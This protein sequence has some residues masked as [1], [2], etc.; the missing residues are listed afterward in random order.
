MGKISARK[1]DTK[2]IRIGLAIEATKTLSIRRAAAKYG[3][4]RSTVQDRLKGTKSPSESKAKY[5]TLTAEEE[6]EI[7]RWIERLDDMAIP[8]RAIHVYQMVGAILA[9][10]PADPTVPANKKPKGMIGKHWISRFL[11]RHPQL[12]SHFAGRID[13]QRVVAGQPAGIQSFFN[14][15]GEVRSRRKI[16][17]SNT[18]NA[19]EKGFTIGQA[20][21]GKV[22]CR[23]RRRNVRVRHPGNREW[24]S[25]MECISADGNVLDPLFIYAG[26]AHLMGNHDY[27]EDEDPAVF[28]ISDNGWTN[29]NIGFLWLKDHFE[30]VTRPANPAEYRL[31]ILDGHSSH[32][33]LE[34]LD[35]ARDHKIEILCF[36]PH[37]THLLQPLDVGIFGP[38]GTYYSN[39]VDNW[40]RTHPY[41]SINKG[42][43]LPMCQRARRKA[44]TKKNIL[45]AFA[46]AGIHSFRRRK[47]LDLVE[48]VT[49][50]Q[51]EFSGLH[52]QNPK[53]L[54]A[55][56]KKVMATK[57]LEELRDWALQL[58]SG[59]D[60]ALTRATIAEETNAQL[61][62]APKKSQSNRKQITKATLVASKYLHK[63]R[64]ERIAKEAAAAEKKQ[65]AATK[66]TATPSTKKTTTT[67]ANKRKAT[68]Q[69]TKGSGKRSRP[70]DSEEDDSNSD[71]S[72]SGG[73]TASAAGFS[74]NSASNPALGEPPNR[75]AAPTRRSA[76]VTR[77]QKV[78][79]VSFTTRRQAVL[80][81]YPNRR[82][83]RRTSQISRKSGLYDFFRALKNYSNFD[84]CFSPCF[85]TINK[86]LSYLDGDSFCGGDSMG[87]RSL[88]LGS[89]SGGR[90]H[91]NG[92]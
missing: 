13:N 86:C 79:L 27:E 68:A 14:R 87:V 23:R 11:D 34:F 89:N 72:E 80:T 47:V 44:F 39:E 8:P 60:G 38:L 28:A 30:V 71:V 31:L 83:A 20:K 66:S 90:S 52:T 62:K 46:E 49:P 50:E 74:E 75:S 45:S 4:P 82:I 29:D 81:K 6:K 55:S 12:A 69:I 77:N 88:R 1:T 37:S 59:M 36:P 19:Y 51:E 10:R 78:L 25:V 65:R 32:L 3:V 84:T 48:S 15:L 56:K 73:G 7:V 33:T 63:L 26:K 22:I 92:R 85:L 5:Q 64:K 18:Y 16:T 58:L 40:T 61:M 67:T 53:A 43:F 76:R 41:Q 24:V 91:P 17:L 2:E 21:K 35:Y 42:D 9:K 70:S 57:D 54:L